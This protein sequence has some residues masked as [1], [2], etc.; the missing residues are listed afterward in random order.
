M[1][2]VPQ[3][4]ISSSSKRVAHA[5][6]YVPKFKKVEEQSLKLL[7]N[8]L[9]GLTL[10]IRKI[11]M[12]KLSAKSLGQFVTRNTLQNDTLSRKRKDEGFNPNA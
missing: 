5:L 1:N 4:D 8:A 9:G 11:D 12:V 3:L 7:G 10:P 2:K 6:H